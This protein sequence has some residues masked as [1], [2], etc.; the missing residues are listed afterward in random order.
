MT[1]SADEKKFIVA[2][3]HEY[4]ARM[5]IYMSKRT[6]YGWTY[7]KKLPISTAGDDRSVFLAADGK[8]LYFASDGY[9]GYGGLDIYKTTLNSDGTFGEV[10][11]VGKPFNTPQDDYGLILTGDGNEAYF[12]RDG[13]IQFADPAVRQMRGSN[14]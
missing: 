10:I 7:C 11:N 9:K 6:A 8:T 2:A 13:S 3:G 4:D 5:D 12:I 14:R 1:I